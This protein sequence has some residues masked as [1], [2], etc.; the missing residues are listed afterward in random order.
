MKGLSGSHR[1]LLAEWIASPDNPLTARVMVNRIWQHHFGT[2]LVSTASDFGSN[3]S[4]TIHESLI[5]WLSA[6]FVESGFS[7]KDMHR[8]IVKSSVYRQ[9]MTHPLAAVYDEIDSSNKY[10]WVRSPFRLEAE[11][12]RDTVLAVSGRL[13][14]DMGGPPFFPE[15]D[16]ELMR[17]TRTWWE[18]SPI[19]ARNRRT[20]YMLQER[21][22][23]LPL[24]KVFDGANM[25]QS[26]PVR[27]T[28]TVTPKVFALFNN[29]S[30]HDQSNSMAERVLNDSGTSVDA[31]VQ[32]AFQLAFQ[33]PPKVHEL[34]TCVH[35][36]QNHQA[37][38]TVT[39]D[40]NSH[41]GAQPH[42]SLADI[43]LVLINSNE[44]IF[45]E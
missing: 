1:K 19:N 3:G 10:L 26:C 20:V 29:K 38:S 39:V 32:R 9:S 23:Q 22:L 41:Q 43:C 36:L 27:E 11:V 2:S 16:D 44:F 13:N 37:K 31:Q 40:G 4:G 7:I 6:R 45:L 33:R 42:G 34:D 21:S 15:V 28:T 30:I 12:I 17:R 18:P 24:V 35:F 14:R 8:L 5:D 25:D